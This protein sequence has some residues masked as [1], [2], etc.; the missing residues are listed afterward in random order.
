MK[1]EGHDV[2]NL[3][4]FEALLRIWQG[5]CQP[6]ASLGTVENVRCVVFHMVKNHPCSLHAGQAA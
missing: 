3:A 2:T 1:D 5:L 4:N 6:E